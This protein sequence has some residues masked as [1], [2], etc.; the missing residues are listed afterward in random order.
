M[1]ERILESEA[2]SDATEKEFCDKELSKTNTKKSDKTAEIDRLSK[3]TAPKLSA[4]R[5]QAKGSK[6]KAEGASCLKT[7]KE[8]EPWTVL[9]KTMTFEVHDYRSLYCFSVY[10]ESAGST[11]QCLD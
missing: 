10:T 9:S 11:K 3:M 2:E 7:C 8:D 1:I 6:N 5:Q 4:A